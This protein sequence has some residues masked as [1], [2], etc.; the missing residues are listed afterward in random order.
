MYSAVVK[1]TKLVS[2]EAAYFV[3]LYLIQWNEAESRKRED[4]G[5]A[6]NFPIIGMAVTL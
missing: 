1:S 3:K 5:L 2:K 4:R 6:L